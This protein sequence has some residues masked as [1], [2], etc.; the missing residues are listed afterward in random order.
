MNLLRVKER[1]ADHLIH[2]VETM[3]FL[4]EKHKIIGPRAQQINY[5][6]GKNPRPIKSCLITTESGTYL[7]G[8]AEAPITMHRERFLSNIEYVSSH[9]CF[10]MLSR[11]ALSS[12][13]AIQSG[14]DS[15]PRTRFRHTP[16]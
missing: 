16:W 8:T 15:Y 7:A 4:I 5:D 12:H 3:P 11:S 6:R 1:G 2:S 10:L 14:S 9:R 13:E